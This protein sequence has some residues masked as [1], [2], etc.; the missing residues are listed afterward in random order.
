ML[1]WGILPLLLIITIEIFYRLPLQMHV[2][3]ML[4]TAL[5]S[6]HIITAKNISDHWKERVLLRYATTLFCTSLMVAAYMVLVCAPLI[7][8]QWTNS[9]L[10]EPLFS[11]Y[12]MS[13]STFFV[14]M[15]LLLRKKIMR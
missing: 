10:I 4:K 6:S 3:N 2:K 8:C 15:Y 5:K 12:G 14:I 13:L 7:L 1:S 11:L 9:Q